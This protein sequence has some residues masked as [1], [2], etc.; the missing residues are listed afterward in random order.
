MS[1]NEIELDE[2][3]MDD[4]IAAAGAVR[5]VLRAAGPPPQP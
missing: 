3:L 1:S 2:R 4:L 5:D